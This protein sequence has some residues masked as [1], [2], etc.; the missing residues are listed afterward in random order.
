MFRRVVKH[1]PT[2]LTETSVSDDITADCVSCSIHNTTT[3][4]HVTFAH[5]HDVMSPDDIISEVGSP[6]LPVTTSG[7]LPCWLESAVERYRR[8]QWSLAVYAWRLVFAHS[9]LRV[10]TDVDR[11]LTNHDVSAATVATVNGDKE[12]L[13]S[14]DRLSRRFHPYL[15]NSH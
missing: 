6:S 9:A 3:Q 10:A 15:T 5:T 13:D 2:L 12:R 7:Q 8:W 14:V 1:V 4:S 11:G